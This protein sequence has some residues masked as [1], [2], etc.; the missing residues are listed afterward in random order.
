MILFVDQSGQLGGAELCLADLAEHRRKESKVVL[1]ADGPFVTHLKN[2]NVAVEVLALPGTAAKITKKAS[3]LS[4]LASA[5]GLLAHVFSLRKKIRE[6]DLVYFNTA[7][8]LV[9]GAAANFP[10]VRPAVFHLH[11]L[12]DP[13]HFSAANIRVL[14]AAA[15]RMDL[16]IANSQ[17]SAEAFEAAGGK[18]P[19]EIVPNGFDPAPFDKVPSEEVARLRA[20]LNPEGRPVAAIFGRL[21][22]WKGQD[23]LLRAAA[24]LPELTVWIV[25]E[26]LFTDDDRAYAEELR[27]LASGMGGRVKFLGFRDDIP[28]LMKAADVV[29]HCSTAPEPF[30]R[31]IVEAMLAR[32]PVIAARA[33]GP[34]EILADSTAGKLVSPGDVGSLE[35]ALRR[36]LASPEERLRLSEAGRERAETEYSLPVVMKKTDAALARFI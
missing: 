20:E 21:A 5:P 7:K 14:V 22:R 4:L 31:V 27:K 11:D 16:V 2:R 33:G 3:P 23:V 19:V 15:N 13:R 26:A 28:A 8:A 10:R 36:L 9:Y 12:L 32:R 29:V 25:G 24:R 30:G 1:F 35:E 6:A 34:I 17:A 18:V